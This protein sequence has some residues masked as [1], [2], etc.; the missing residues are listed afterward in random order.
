MH[1]TDQNAALSLLQGGAG[2]GLEIIQSIFSC[3][4]PGEGKGGEER[5][6]KGLDKC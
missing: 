1:S 3:H 2:N 5:S 6:N 4:G